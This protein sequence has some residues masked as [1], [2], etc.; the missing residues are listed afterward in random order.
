MIMIGKMNLGWDFRI[1]SACELSSSS[2]PQHRRR[3]G[4]PFM[5]VYLHEDAG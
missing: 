1:H 2:G 4:L 3:Y 5:S